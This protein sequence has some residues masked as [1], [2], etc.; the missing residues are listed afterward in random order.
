MEIE[1]TNVQVIE[2]RVGLDVEH[3]RTPVDFSTGKYQDTAFVS[4]VSISRTNELQFVLLRKAD[5]TSE[6]AIMDALGVRKLAV[7]REHPD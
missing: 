4:G 5:G 3:A 1:G 2:L 7:T 6:G